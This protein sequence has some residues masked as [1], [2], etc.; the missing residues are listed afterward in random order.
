MCNMKFHHLLILVYI[1]TLSI[2]F[3]NGFS[4]LKIVQLH[5]KH[6]NSSKGTEYEKRKLKFL[7]TLKWPEHLANFFSESGL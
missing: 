3:Y 2:Y 6:L 4:L 1:Y 7:S 5:E